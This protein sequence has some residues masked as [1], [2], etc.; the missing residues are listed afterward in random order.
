[1]RVVLDLVNAFNGDDLQPLGGMAE[2]IKGE[3]RTAMGTADRCTER[4]GVYIVQ[5]LA[6]QERIYEV[7]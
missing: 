4:R 6:I 5:S 1:M 3:Q 7:L 2:H